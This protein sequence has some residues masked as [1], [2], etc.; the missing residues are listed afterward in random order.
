MRSLYLLLS[1]VVF[2]AACGVEAAAP[3]TSSTSSS[4]STTTSTSVT[5]TTTTLP[6]ESTTTSEVEF[7]GPEPLP[8]DPAYTLLLDGLGHFG[9][10]GD[11]A[12]PI[13]D[14]MLESFG[15][16]AA[17]SE[18]IEEHGCV[19]EGPMRT[20][21]WV[22]PGIRV[23]FVDGSSDL[24]EGEHLSSYTTLQLGFAEPAT[25]WQMFGI[26]RGINIAD[27]GAMFPDA[28]VIPAPSFD[29][30]QLDPDGLSFARVDGSGAITDFWAGIDYCSGD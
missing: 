9:G 30:V 20:I 12:Q 1:L 17:D 25:P 11:P 27:L 6:P 16:P 21:T 2:V 15:E 28:S 22:G 29:Y 23:V 10:L 3:T 7:Q 14:A 4:T 18:W 5:S 13:I 24:G 8:D 19:F 26:R